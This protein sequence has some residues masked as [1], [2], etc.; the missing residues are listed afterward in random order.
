[1]SGLEVLAKTV[2]V[3]SGLMVNQSELRV[4]S[5]CPATKRVMSGG[6]NLT[7][8]WARTLTVLTSFPELAGASVATDGWVVEFRN[9]T[10]TVLPAFSVTV[11]AICVNR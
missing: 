9:N 7:G 5:P 6:Y 11:Y 8:I 3:A 1:V 4:S 10:S 2:S